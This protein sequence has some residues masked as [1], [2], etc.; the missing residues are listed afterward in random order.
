M[1]KKKDAIKDKELEKVAGGRIND[2]SSKKAKGDKMINLDNKEAI[3]RKDEA[4][5]LQ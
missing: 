3:K 5:L 2:L 1:A 4:I